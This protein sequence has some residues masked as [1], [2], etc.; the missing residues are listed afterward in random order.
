MPKL[1]WPLGLSQAHWPK[2]HP[3]DWSAGKK[4]QQ[5]WAKSKLWRNSEAVVKLAQ[6]STNR[7]SFVDEPLGAKAETR[8]NILVVEPNF[9]PTYQCST[10]KDKVYGLCKKRNGEVYDVRTPSWTEQL[11]IFHQFW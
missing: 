11:L 10:G 9:P 5:I 3:E 1:D 8:N 6:L 2:M 7:D 4:T